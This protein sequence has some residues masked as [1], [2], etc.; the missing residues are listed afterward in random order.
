MNPFFQAD[1]VIQIHAMAA[2]TALILGGVQLA[3]PKGGGRHRLMGWGWVLAMA[4]TA[5][6][7]FWIHEIRLIGDWS[8]IHILSIVT[9]ANLPF[10]VLAARRK[11]FDRHKKIVLSLFTFG[12]LVAGGFT[13]L[14]G[15]LMHVSLFG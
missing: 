11:R 12:L 9:L 2:L 1:P 13:L 6:S 3:L 5:T 10:L 14:P 4:V 8:P 7:S 15:R